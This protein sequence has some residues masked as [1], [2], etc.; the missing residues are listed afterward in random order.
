M[1]EKE[2]RSESKKAITAQ[3]NPNSESELK[4]F[5]EWSSAEIDKAFRRVVSEQETADHKVAWLANHT[6]E[7]VS[8]A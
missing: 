7:R 8:R 4:P 3:N 6:I 2:S 1:E 5:H